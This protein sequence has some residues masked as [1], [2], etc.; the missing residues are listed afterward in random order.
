VHLYRL[1]GTSQLLLLASQLAFLALFS[2][3]KRGSTGLRSV[4]GSCGNKNF[5]GGASQTCAHSITAADRALVVMRGSHV[6][7]VP[8]SELQSCAGAGSGRPLGERKQSLSKIQSLWCST[9]HA[10]RRDS[11]ESRTRRGNNE[12]DCIGDTTGE[13]HWTSDRSNSIGAT[14]IAAANSNFLCRR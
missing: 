14:S 13:T 10:T 6:P 7:H 8:S 1:V 2:A 3:S 12:A 4:G 11:E 5:E 9:I